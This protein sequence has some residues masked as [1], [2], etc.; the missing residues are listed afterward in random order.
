LGFWFGSGAR[1]RSRLPFHR[2]FRLG[3]GRTPGSTLTSAYC[4][5][6]CCWFSCHRKWSFYDVAA[7]LL[8]LLI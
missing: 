8:F 3:F 7:K 2:F 4:R 5:R 1:S 6:L